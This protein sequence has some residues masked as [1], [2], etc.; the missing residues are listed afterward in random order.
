MANGGVISTVAVN[1]QTALFEWAPKPR[2]VVPVKF[3]VYIHESR[4]SKTGFACEALAELTSNL[5]IPVL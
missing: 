3:P 5:T 2:N 4:R 1:R